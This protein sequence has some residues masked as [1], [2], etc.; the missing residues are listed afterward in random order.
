ME[1]RNK[2]YKPAEF[3]KIR[4]GKS[5]IGQLETKSRNSGGGCYLAEAGRVI[6]RGKNLIKPRRSIRYC[7]QEFEFLWER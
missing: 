1:R 7:D 6:F 5:V 2:L 4:C 3:A